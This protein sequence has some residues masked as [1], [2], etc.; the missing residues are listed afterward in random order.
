MAIGGGE[1]HLLDLCR[2]LSARG[3]HV[4]LVVRP[5]S[6]LPDRLGSTPVTIH[7]L[8]L[9]NAIDLLSARALSRM[10]RQHQ[11]DIIHG[12]VARDYP[13]CLLAGKWAGRGRVVLTRHHY[14]PLRVNWLNRALFRRVG[15]VIAVSESVRRRLI[16]SLP[17]SADRIVTIPN[18]IDPDDYR[19]LPPAEQ[20]RRRLGLN[21]PLVVGMVGQMTP[22][23]G[24]E[25]F[26]RAAALVSAS[27]EDVAFLLVGSEQGGRRFTSRCQRLVRRLGIAHRVTFLDHI[28]DLSWVWSALTVLVVPSWQEAFSMVLIQAMA[29]GLP[30]IATRVGGPAEIVTHRVTGWLVPPREIQSLAEAIALLLDD[31]PLRERLGRAARAEVHERFDRS[32]II[33]RIESVYRQVIIESRDAVR[34]P[35]S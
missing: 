31:A 21:A 18:W 11:I 24:Q 7:Q 8:P 14:L 29:A 30:V 2:A 23:K 27:R 15:K 20:A 33:A 6:P 35:A 22:A 10:I 17:I 28:E 19:Q 25:E 34:S 1:I 32:R 4:Q 26:L 12:H 3:H 13:L 9:R 5:N 16:A